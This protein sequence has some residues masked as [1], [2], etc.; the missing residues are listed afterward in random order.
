MS[1]S[2]VAS[3]TGARH[4]LVAPP[5]AVPASAAQV[6]GVHHASV[7][8]DADPG[9]SAG[10]GVA[11]DADLAAT[12]AVAESL[13][14]W[15][16]SVATLPLRRAS[17]VPAGEQ[18]SPDAWTL[19]APDQRRD[20]AFPHS[21]AYPAD[22]WL[23]EAYDL[24][25]NASRWVPAALVSLT[26]DFGALATSSGLAADP[27]VTK[28]LLRATQELV[29]RD[30]YVA[31][32]L[33][34]LGGREVPVPAFAAEVAPL[35]GVVRA[36]DCT[37]RFSPHPVALV[38]GTLPLGGSPRHS[39][40]VACRATWAEAVERAYLEMLQGTVF[41]GHVL[42]A[43]PE[44]VGMAPGAVTGFDEHAVYYAANPRRWD[45]VPLLRHAE[46]A[47]P[48][49]VRAPEADPSPEARTGTSGETPG[50]S[51]V[52]TGTPG[53]R[54]GTSGVTTGT[55]GERPGT[56]GEGSSPARQ[57]HRL[58]TAL[59]EA[60][61]RLYYRELTTDDCNQLGLRVVRVLSPDLTPLHHDHRWPFLGGTTADVAWRYP[62][63]QQRR[64]N[65]PFPSPHP[66]A[67]G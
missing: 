36:F 28:A 46:P 26:D 7:P 6:A 43:H 2:L 8:L 39:L 49:P 45:E 25:T 23:T 60:G 55:P 56:P 57:L 32:W 29:E 20:P 34:Q 59:G 33:H 17:T 27:S 67:L 40:G 21:A 41:V 16:A 24:V 14:R 4:G 35:G 44:L 64:G 1:A 11:R 51:G 58:V 61:V 19:H 65:R 63:A 38:A 30:A 15:A 66:H 9:R 53:E 31:T 10:G 62:E 52:R 50:T 3:A 42:S 47:P 18:V 54:P 13:E 12:A 22:P 5:A 37:P 48:P